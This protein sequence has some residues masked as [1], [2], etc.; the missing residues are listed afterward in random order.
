MPDVV[1][2][3]RRPVKKLSS[4]PDCDSDKSFGRK[5]NLP[6]SSDKNSVGVSKIKRICDKKEG[7]KKHFASDDDLPAPVITNYDVTQ[8]SS[9]NAYEYPIVL[10]VAKDRVAK[11][12]V[13]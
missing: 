9:N 8:F 12:N 10:K 2:I 11:T 7:N 3:I 6:N 1:P 4:P 5:F 13:S